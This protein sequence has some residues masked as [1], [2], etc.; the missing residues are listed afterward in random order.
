MVWREVDSSTGEF[1]V[2]IL[3][4]K[5]ISGYFYEPVDV[6]LITDDVERFA[7]ITQFDLKK[8]KEVVENVDYYI[9]NSIEFIKSELLS[10]PELFGITALEADKYRDVSATDFPVDMPEICFNPDKSWFIKFAYADFPSVEY[11]LGVIVHFDMND[12]PFELN[13]PSMKDIDC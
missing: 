11:G 3:E 7:D 2:W 5:I 1:H 12:S 8:V 9:T 10:T 6:N 13:I 4:D